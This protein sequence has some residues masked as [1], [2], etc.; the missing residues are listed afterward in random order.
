MAKTQHSSAARAPWRRLV[1]LTVLAIALAVALTIGSITG[2]KSRWTPDF[3]L[4]LEGGTELILT[5]KTTNG[6]QV[7]Q[8]DINQAIAIIRQRV[9][10]SGV[11]EAEISS[12][13]GS[14]IVVAL[15]GHPSEETLNLVRTSA[16]LRMR[17]VLEMATATPLT[18][19]MYEQATGK[20]TTPDT[21][22]T[23]GSSETA[24][25]S[26][27]ASA[28]A[29]ATS[30]A[31][32][33]ASASAS[34][35]ASSS[36]SQTP[37]TGKE[38]KAKALELADANGDGKIS[39][40][41]SGTP[42]NSSDATWASSEQ[43][44]YDVLTMDCTGDNPQSAATDDPKKALVACG[45]GGTKFVLGPADIEGTDISQASPGFDQQEGKYIVQLQFNS[46]GAKEFADITGRLVSLQSPQ[47]EFAIVLDGHVISNPVP[48]QQI[49]GGQASISGGGINAQSAKTLANQLQFGSLPLQFEV[50]SE[51]QISATLGTES[52]SAG[53]IAGLVGLLLIVMYL[54]WQYHALGV[55]A[56]GS[57]VL[58]TGLSYL[59]VCLLSWTMGYR[60]S[61]AGVVGLVI[62]IGISADSFIVFFERIRDEIR[63][64][65]SLRSS[66]SRGWHRAK[67]TIF[68]SDGVNL[69][70][71]IVLYLAAVGS[72]RGF[73]FTLGITTILD[74]VVVIMFTYPMMMRLVRTRFF[75]EGHR[76]SG[77]S[78][79]ALGRAPRYT[80]RGTT[81]AAQA[82]VTLAERRAAQRR[83]ANGVVVETAE[84]DTPAESP[85]A[86]EEAK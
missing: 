9:D 73:A 16:V 49:N 45:E 43:V 30:N 80:G 31:S 47:N 79:E 50:Q 70:A 53:L 15:P 20:S 75:G 54:I 7:T 83:A 55:V 29:S 1:V 71:A 39:D 24:S 65:H 77:M 62:S 28:S 19:A 60:L 69:V 25:A 44:L 33:E 74:L 56:I 11:A 23:A 12:Q 22:A 34:P 52:L 17:P 51:Q 86:E 40:T 8:D 46:K 64:G 61:L 35:S 27:T 84:T 82:G 76:W 36:A 4:D 63:D 42:K 72:V 14:N 59:I 57:V 81:R 2:H 3:A 5:P 85:T 78:A 66:V 21:S 6:S 13:G 26:G 38:L 37:Y 32:T 10:A 18:P 67:R 58:A 41:V 68:V 48:N